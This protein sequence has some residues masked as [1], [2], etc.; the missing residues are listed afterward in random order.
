M[1]QVSLKATFFYPQFAESGVTH[2]RN[3]N[4]GAEKDSS[5][6]R[7]LTLAESKDVVNEET[8]TYV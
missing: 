2:V 8:W 7:G 1:F 6:C 5:E 4:H 3:E